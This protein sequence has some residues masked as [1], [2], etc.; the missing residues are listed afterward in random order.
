MPTLCV[1]YAKSMRTLCLAYAK[2]RHQSISVPENVSVQSLQKCN[3]FLRRATSVADG[4]FHFVAQFGEGLAVALW[5][6]DGVVAETLSA[7]L[8][9]GDLSIA[10]ALEEIRLP[11]EVQGDA[12]AE[13]RL[14]VGLAAH[15]VEHL[16]DVVLIAAMLARITCRIHARGTAQSLHFEARVVGEA[17]HVE[18]VGDEV[19]LDLGVA[20]DGVGIFDDFL[21]AADFLKAHDLIEAVHDFAHLAQFVLIVCS[22]YD[23]FHFSLV[24]GIVLGQEI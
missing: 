16:V 10:A 14:A 6:E 13:S 20:F 22:E 24:L 21:M 7:T 12:G 18:L 15:G 2:K 3:Q 8:L 4:I 1:E 19:G 11:V 9:L 5:L 23:L 17:V